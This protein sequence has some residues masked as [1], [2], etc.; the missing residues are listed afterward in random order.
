[1]GREHVAPHGVVAEV[2]LVHGVQH[3]RRN[4]QRHR[5]VDL[6]VALDVVGELVREIR[7]EDVLELPD[8][9]HRVCELPG[10]RLPLLA[11]DLA[12]AGQPPPIGLGEIAQRLR[13][14]VQRDVLDELH[15]F[16]TRQGRAV[17]P[18]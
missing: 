18:R 2:A 11:H 5:R 13:G 12:E 14:R 9:L 1:V 3:V 10:A 8:V 7:A 6:L 16:R 17:F 4:E 15:V